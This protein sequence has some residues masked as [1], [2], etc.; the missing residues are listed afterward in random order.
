MLLAAMNPC[1]C[2]YAGDEE[3][4]CQCSPYQVIRYQQK[5]SGPIMDRIDLQISVPRVPLRRLSENV[6]AE[7]SESIQRRVIRAREI[8]RER[9]VD[10]RT[11]T[12][13]EMDSVLMK[14]CILLSAENK[15]FFHQAATQL[16]L[17]ARGYT[18]VL[19]V[20][21]TIADLE[22]AERVEQKHLAEALQYRF[23]HE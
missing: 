14:K 11:L 17:S 10:S 12:N 9:F 15:E 4:L 22:E 1:P 13:A 18:R 5:I 16:Q 19:K 21:R 7:K 3:R 8:Q 23:T 6:L 20:A 2:G